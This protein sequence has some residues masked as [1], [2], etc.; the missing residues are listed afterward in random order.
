MKL[1]FQGHSEKKVE[2]KVSVG[3][4]KGTEGIKHVGLIQRAVAAD[5]V[6]EPQWVGQEFFRSLPG[7]WCLRARVPV[8]DVAGSG[9]GRRH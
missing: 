4:G 3:Q 5:L 6:D 9:T 7:I 2:K 8:A 1:P